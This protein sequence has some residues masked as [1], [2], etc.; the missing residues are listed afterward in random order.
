M[1]ASPSL[2][3]SVGAELDNHAASQEYFIIDEESSNVADRTLTI[4]GAAAADAD[5]NLLHHS[6]KVSGGLK[7]TDSLNLSAQSEVASVSMCR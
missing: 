7:H 2:R 4:S 6:E 3:A 1:E 5:G